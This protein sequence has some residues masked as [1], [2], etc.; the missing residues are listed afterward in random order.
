M[1]SENDPEQEKKLQ[2]AVWK[3]VDQIAKE[4]S[5]NLG[6]AISKEYIASLANLVYKQIEITGLDIEAFTKHA[7]R[8]T[9]SMDDVLLCA[10]R[11]DGL[12]DILAEKSN[13]ISANRK[14][15]VKKSKKRQT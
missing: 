2:V 12:Y 5:S 11:N 4:E 3:I 6:M 8:S 9:I 15:D 14:S 7:H 13:E 10:R 1:A